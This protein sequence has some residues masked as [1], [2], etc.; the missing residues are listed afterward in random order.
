MDQCTRGG[1]R[2]GSG[3]GGKEC[4]VRGDWPYSGL[5]SDPG[6][7]AMTVFRDFRTC[8]DPFPT[9]RS[10]W[11]S[12]GKYPEAAGL[13]PKCKRVLS[14]LSLLIR[15]HLFADKHLCPPPTVRH[16]WIARSG[17]YD[18]AT[19]QA[20]NLRRSCPSSDHR[21]PGR[22]CPAPSSGAG[23]RGVGRQP[24]R[25]LSQ[26]QTEIPRVRRRPVG[27]EE[28]SARNRSGGLIAPR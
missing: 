24:D 13:K 9:V 6:I 21:P 12:V 15:Q 5:Y 14:S 11:F 23:E 4:P 1:Q 22:I 17:H 18:K 3:V 16:A 19:V 28:S 10:Q 25:Q 7:V 8:R 2:A 26:R 27:S 20:S